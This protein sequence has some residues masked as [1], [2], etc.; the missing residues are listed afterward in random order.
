MFNVHNHLGWYDLK[1][2]DWICK[3]GLHGRRQLRDQL[4]ARPRCKGSYLH[5]L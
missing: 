4:P 3:G 5:F 2:V 1:A